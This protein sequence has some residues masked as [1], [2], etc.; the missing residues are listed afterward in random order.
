MKEPKVH[1][2]K[3]IRGYHITRLFRKETYAVP[4][5]PAYIKTIR[6]SCDVPAAKFTT[7][8]KYTETIKHKLN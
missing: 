5:N 7:T 2:N 4:I 8:E 3:W 6:W 1:I